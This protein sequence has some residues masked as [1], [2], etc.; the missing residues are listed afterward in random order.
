MMHNLLHEAS[1]AIT[2]SILFWVK[3]VHQA[4]LAI[5][6]A[7]GG[8]VGVAASEARTR[9]DTCTNTASWGSTAG[10]AVSIGAVAVLAGE[11]GSSAVSASVGAGAV[12]ADGAW[13]ALEAVVALLTAG[14]DTALLLEV[15]HG[16]GWES[17]GG[18]VLCRVVMHLVD[19]NGGVGN[20]WLNGLLVDDWLD[21]LVDVVVHV[22]TAN[23]WS[24]AGGVLALNTLGRVA[25]LGGGLVQLAVDIGLVA[26]LEVAV[27]DTDQV[28]VVLLWESLGVLNWLDGG[29]VVVLVNLLVDSGG[30]VVM[31]GACDS[32]VLDC[33]SNLLVD[34]GV[35]LTGLGHEVRNCCLCLVHVDLVW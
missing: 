21:G 34:G 3:L 32:L 26:M 29:V 19:G 7:L 14:E 22:L 1:L 15:G 4:W 27:L 23:G 10:V 12:A 16:D 30:D 13:L 6:V 20:V 8:V 9:T 11:A 24:L 35:V 2:I 18:V 5:L 25:E 28:V 17:G 31:V 33:W